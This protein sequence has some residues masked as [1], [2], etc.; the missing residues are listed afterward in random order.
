MIPKSKPTS[1]IK[2]GSFKKFGIAKNTKV[3][4]PS[5]PPVTV[6]V[7]ADVVVVVVAVANKL[8]FHC[9]HF[10]QSNCLES[11]TNAMAELQKR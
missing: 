11:P 6:V 8:Y 5:L 4:F 7:A 1:S 2:R 10:S 9:L 3:L